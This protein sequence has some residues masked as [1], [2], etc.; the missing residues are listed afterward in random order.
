MGPVLQAIQ[1]S[2]PRT[3]EISIEAFLPIGTGTQYT[4]SYGSQVLKYTLNNPSFLSSPTAY[5]ALVSGYQ[6]ELMNTYSTVFINSENKTWQPKIGRFTYNKS[7]TVG[8][9]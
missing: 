7:W 8:D 6:L 5:D 2:T 3:R 9:C 4:Q 1:A